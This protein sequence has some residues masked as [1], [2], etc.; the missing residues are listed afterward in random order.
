MDKEIRYIV[1]LV[2]DSRKQGKEK[3]FV[4][5]KPTPEFGSACFHSQGVWMDKNP[6][7]NKVKLDTV[8]MRD[9]WIPWH[10]IDHITNAVYRPK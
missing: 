4:V 2:T 7:L 3:W 5:L 1:H 9:E 10:R 6:E 8:P